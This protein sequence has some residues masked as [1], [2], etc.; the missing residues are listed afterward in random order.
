[1]VMGERQG[2]RASLGLRSIAT[3]AVSI[4]G[5][6]P[7]APADF[8]EAL[9]LAGTLNLD[10]LVT[11]VVPLHRYAAAFDLL[12]MDTAGSTSSSYRAMKV[13]LCSD[14]ELAGGS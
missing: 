10:A 9:R 7:Y 6:G 3:R 14:P 13:L 1:V 12:C 2:A 5:A 11:H 8:A 4:R